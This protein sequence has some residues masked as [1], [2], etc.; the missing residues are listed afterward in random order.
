M[1]YGKDKETWKEVSP[2]H[3]HNNEIATTLESTIAIHQRTC[4]PV[5]PWQITRVFLSTHTLAVDDMERAAP[6]RATTAE[7]LDAM[8]LAFMVLLLLWYNES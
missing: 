5:K 3:P 4:L 6:G 8:A 7:I 2:A 1:P